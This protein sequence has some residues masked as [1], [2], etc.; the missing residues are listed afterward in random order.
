MPCNVLSG[1]TGPARRYDLG[2]LLFKMKELEKAE[3]V[4]LEAVERVGATGDQVGHVDLGT[5]IEGARSMALLARIYESGASART[6]DAI[7]MLHDARDLQTRYSSSSTR[8]VH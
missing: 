4:L 3:R 1:P 8:T 5:L 2:N 6:R 7:R